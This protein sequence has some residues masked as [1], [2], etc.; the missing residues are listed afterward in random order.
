MSD[1]GEMILFDSST[2]DWPTCI[3]GF[4]QYEL[5]NILSYKKSFVFLV[6]VM[7]VNLFKLLYKLRVSVKPIEKTFTWIV[8]TAQN[9][10]AP[11]LLMTSDHF[12][13]HNFFWSGWI[14]KINRA[15]P[16]QR[17]YTMH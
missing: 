15:L 8:E 3:S 1:L 14:K 13:F 2:E 16:V 11:K 5:T 7:V 6:G 10:L 17:A 12:H 9:Y 4:R